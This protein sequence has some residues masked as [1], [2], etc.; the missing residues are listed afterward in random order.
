MNKLEIEKLL[1]FREPFLMID[2]VVVEEKG[3]KGK[4]SKTLTGGE[5]FFEGHF[6]E[7]PV[8]P[9]VLI[10]EAIA[11][12]SMVVAGRGDLKLKGMEKIKFR[13]TIIPNDTLKINVELIKETEKEYIFQGEV[14]VDENLAASGN[15]LLVVK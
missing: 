8:M 5:Y 7:R 15:I 9:G 1:P 3:K 4:G 13:Q 10:V 11:Q 2:E 6:P 14:Y 12:T